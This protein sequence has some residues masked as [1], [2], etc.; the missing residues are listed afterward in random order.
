MIPAKFL[1][2][3]SGRVDIVDVVGRYVPLKKRGTNFVGLCPFHAEKTPSFTVS[4]VK[5]VY[6][7]FGC[8]VHG[9]TIG[10]LMEHMELT[11]PDAVDALA[12]LANMTVPDKPVSRGAA[13]VAGA[14]A[15]PAP[16]VTK[17]FRETLLG[18]M[19]KACEFYCTRL[20][21]SPQAIAYLKGRGVTDEVAQRF[22]VGYA[23]ALWQGLEDA[24]DDY[25]SAA[26]VGAGLVVTSD[27]QD[28][29]GRVRR[30]DLFRNRIMFPVLDAQGQVIGFGARA[31]DRSKPKYLNSPETALF[32][33]GNELYGL[34][35]A[36]SAIRERGYVLV[37]EGYMDVLAL[38][39][40]GFPNVVATMGTACTA[41]HVQKLLRQTDTIVFC[42]DGDTAGSRAS[43]RALQACLPCAAD[44]R[45]IRFLF[46]PPQHDP[47][48]YVR[49]L[50]AQAF[51]Q[52]VK[53]AMPLSQFLFN[54]ATL[55]RSLEHPEGRARALAEAKPLLQALPQNALRAQILRMFAQRLNVSPG[56]IGLS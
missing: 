5:Q 2:D 30:Y 38:A 1:Q 48:S 13:P 41:A 31:H 45:T 25:E 29:H 46:L 50:G 28:Q 3:L 51:A 7:C 26:L 40:C 11:F 16:H 37:V 32:S 42:F 6:H 21:S 52:Q 19:R 4:P 49:E 17:D 53:L 36:R 22:G 23:P 24:F 20:H 14:L 33:K 54:E 35:E 12:K 43:R 34:F 47:D 18:V 56:E 9:T 44:N 27:R 15:K 39:Q 8:G 10:F 55:G